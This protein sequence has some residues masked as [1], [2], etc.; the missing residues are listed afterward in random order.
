MLQ[1]LESTIKMSTFVALVLRRFYIFSSLLTLLGREKYSLPCQHFANILLSVDS[2]TG[3]CVHNVTPPG[4]PNESRRS[5][6]RV[7]YFTNSL[8]DCENMAGH[9]V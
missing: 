3:I 8:S 1:F 9:Q 2:G 5:T 4:G 6:R 7:G